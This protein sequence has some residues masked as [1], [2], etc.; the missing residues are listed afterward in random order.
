MIST[1]TVFCLIYEYLQKTQSLSIWK[2]N[3]LL[4]QCFQLNIGWNLSFIVGGFTSAQNRI[5]NFHLCS[6]DKPAQ[7]T[8]TKQAT[9]ESP[10]VFGLIQTAVIRISLMSPSC[11]AGCVSLRV[12][13]SW[14]YLTIVPDVRINIIN[15]NRKLVTV[16]YFNM[17]YFT[18]SKL[19][20]KD[21]MTSSWQQLLPVMQLCYESVDW[22]I[23]LF[24]N[25]KMY[26]KACSS[27]P[28][29]QVS[30]MH[31]TTV[32]AKVSLGAKGRMEF[33]LYHYRTLN[34]YWSSEKVFK[35]RAKITWQSD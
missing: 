8:K 24:T 17:D 3:I 10:E 34:S 29:H 25:M 15:Q 28:V 12:Y 16:S 35:E 31:Q 7:S 32:F 30:L 33:N 23:L 1:F 4:V 9:A 27:T 19:F 26:L 18:Q 20:L 11:A 21:L 5:L 14:K 13:Q 22:L 2:I 6:C